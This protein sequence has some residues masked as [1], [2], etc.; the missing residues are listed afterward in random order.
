[1]RQ[2]TERETVSL[3][4]PSEPAR[5]TASLHVRAA[6][7]SNQVPADHA[8]AA[9]ARADWH[10]PLRQ[11]MQVHS[12]CCGMLRRLARL[13]PACV[14]M[15]AN[16]TRCAGLCCPACRQARRASASVIPKAHDVCAA[17]AQQCASKLSKTGLVVQTR[18]QLLRLGQ[19]QCRAQVHARAI[20][21]AS[22]GAA[23]LR[24][25]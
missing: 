21:P 10:P 23:L 19:A 4:M 14:S 7:R 9:C 2:A 22:R 3:H 18:G 1:M 6:Q 12:Q 25:L 5:E 24:P 15:L 11:H 17:G 8:V 16:K 13:Q 20:C